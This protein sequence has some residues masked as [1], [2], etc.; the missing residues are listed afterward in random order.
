MDRTTSVKLFGPGYGEFAT[1]NA[2]DG[3][4][5]LALSVPTDR[6]TTPA[7]VE[8]A[9]ISSTSAR[10]FTAASSE[11]WADA[12]TALAELKSAATA[13]TAG[14][15]PPLLKAELT[16]RVASLTAA[17]DAEQTEEAGQ[18]AIAVA[19]VTFDLK[20]R[21]QL[22]TEVDRM[23]FDLWLAQTTLDVSANDAGGVRGD[24]ATA[25]LVFERFRHTLSPTLAADI[26][27]RLAD[28]RAAAKASNLAQSEAIAKELHTMIAADGW[29]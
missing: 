21:H 15:L 1:T 23:R 6:V 17:V 7:P 22:P 9:T 13:L 3:T 5:P 28:L 29:K 26:T 16:A 12:K 8:L 11:K 25:E 20:L 4:E 2:K 27:K 10:V 19:R 24:V 14:T 18:E